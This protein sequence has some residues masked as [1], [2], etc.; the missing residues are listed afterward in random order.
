LSDLMGVILPGGLAVG[1]VTLVNAYKTWR[2]GRHTREE[3]VLGRLQRQLREADRRIQTAEDDE[4]YATV[5]A[6]HWMQ[7]SAELEYIMRKNGITPPPR[8][9]LPDRPVRRGAS[10]APARRKA[11]QTTE[12][13][14]A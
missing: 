13:E 11:R 5:I 9:P 12:D 7:R 2:D 10:N 1:V 4:T 8:L 14:D 3:T 6:D